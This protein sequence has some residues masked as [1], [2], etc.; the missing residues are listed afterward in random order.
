MTFGVTPQLR[1]RQASAYS[2]TNNAGCANRVSLMAAS[3]L[4]ARISL[5]ISNLSNGSSSSAH[6]SIA[7]RKTLCASYSPAA[8]TGVL[9]A[10]AAKQKRDRTRAA[11]VLRG[12]DRMRGCGWRS[13]SIACASLLTDNCAAVAKRLPADLQGPF[14]VRK[15]LIPAFAP[16]K[17]ARL[18]VI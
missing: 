3:L 11:L 6:R 1:H 10:L 18:F 4:F 14:D 2:T 16:R 13:S 12:Q 8:H 9:G 15:R 5:R 7:S 17:S